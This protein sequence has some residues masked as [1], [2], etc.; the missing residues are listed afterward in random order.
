MTHVILTESEEHMLKSIFKILEI[1]VEMVTILANIP[2]FVKIH[3]HI[4]AHCLDKGKQLNHA[5]KGCY[6][7]K[8][9]QKNE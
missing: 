1:S 7:A 6:W 4:C 9:S 5:E 2:G 3:R 8:K